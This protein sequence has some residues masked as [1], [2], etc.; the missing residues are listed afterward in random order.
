MA[1]LHWAGKVLRKWIWLLGFVP[2]LL[3]YV[4]VY[5]P[6]KCFPEIVRKLISEG[7]NWQLTGGFIVLGA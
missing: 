3:D 2:L 6:Q 5:I 7:A 1:F 4:M